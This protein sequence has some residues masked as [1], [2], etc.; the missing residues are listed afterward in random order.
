ML[1]RR[2]DANASPMR[3]QSLR[4][5]LVWRFGLLSAVARR[6]IVLRRAAARSRP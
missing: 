6:L 1:Y 4:Q 5:M 3:R 2:H